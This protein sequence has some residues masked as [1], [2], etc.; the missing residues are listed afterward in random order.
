MRRMLVAGSL[1]LAV[2]VAA[3]GGNGD[4]SG[5]DGLLWVTGGRYPGLDQATAGTVK[6]FPV[7]AEGDES[8][9][10]QLVRVEP[11]AA[12]AVDSTGEF[13]IT[14]PPGRYLLAAQMVGGH[15]CETPWVEV[16]S[17]GYTSITI[18][19]HIR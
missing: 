1:A 18:T 10:N 15:A 16:N 8:L 3:C 4:P 19:C 14:M 7:T 6:V 9:I 12:L 11:I 2:V 17:G 13:R 5:I